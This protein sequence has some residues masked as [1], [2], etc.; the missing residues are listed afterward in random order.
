MRISQAEI[1]LV[2]CVEAGLTVFLHSQPGTG[3]T[4]LVERIA[5]ASGVECRALSL[6]LM[7]PEDIRVPVP[8]AAGLSWR[9]ADI[10]PREGR[11]ILFLD[12][13]P[14]AHESVQSVFGQLLYQGRLDE[15]ELPAGWAV[16]CAGN[17]LEDRAA[18]HAIPTQIRNRVVHLQLEPSLEDWLQYDPE[19]LPRV[20]IERWPERKLEDGRPHPLMAAIWKTR[21]QTLS[22]PSNWRDLLAWPSPRTLSLASA[23]LATRPELDE[24]DWR[25]V[26]GL[27]GEPAA[28]ELRTYAELR[29]ELPTLEEVMEGRADA[30]KVTDPVA[31]WVAAYSLAEEAVREGEPA[32][33]AVLDFCRPWGSVIEAALFAHVVRRGAAMGLK[34]YQWRC[35]QRLAVHL[36]QTGIVPVAAR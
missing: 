25:V 26:G 28:A 36:D 8:T 24:I 35:V 31:R 5:R 34:V 18:A 15:Y 12:E 9:Y 2:R 29:H 1:A 22:T 32:M 11:G 30:S 4:K 17:R 23:Y 21:P 27:I 3:K 33:A 13:F 16:V 6:A 14:Q 7:Q 20:R 10:L 19:V